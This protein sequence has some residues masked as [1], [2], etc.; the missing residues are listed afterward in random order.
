MT[1]ARSVVAFAPDYTASRAAFIEQARAVRAELSQHPIA[2]RGPSGEPL[3]MDCAYTGA[4]IPEVLAIITSGVHGVE[5]PAGSALQRLWLH[6]LAGQLDPSCGALFVH[7]LNPYGFAHG[8]RVNENNVDLNRNALIRFPGP[9]N[10]AYRDVDAWLNPRT[11]C[12]ARDDFWLGAVRHAL[13]VGRTA[14][15]QAVAGGQY[16]FPQG[17]FF[18]G[19]ETQESLRLF[20]EQLANPKFAAVR[21]V[22][23]LDV[24]TGLG[25]YGSYKILVDFPRSDPKFM[26]LARRFGA[27]R[28]AS[29]CPDDATFY[30]AHGLLSEVTLR[31]FPRASV[32]A[33][34]V[35]FG[36]YSATRV[37]KILRM[38]N[39]AAHFGCKSETAAS[40]IKRQMR[41]TFHPPDPVWCRDVLSHGTRIAAQLAEHLREA[42]QARTAAAPAISTSR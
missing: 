7:A 1:A 28:V 35:E 21:D 13:R 20:S 30:A 14:L 27:D 10:A 42:A 38:E 26:P 32:T 36:T 37:L 11:P 2:A 16:E 24:H 41:E 40:R 19:T 33:A 18:G 15:Q 22:L 17:L 34:V 9:E 29:D 3:T 39:R 6:E 23:H 25:E 4:L 12:A 31:A 8:R 5:G